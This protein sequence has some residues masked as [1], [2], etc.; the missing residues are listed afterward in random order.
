MSK[1]ARPGIKAEAMAMMES[2]STA[3]EVSVLTGIEIMTLHQMR[4]RFFGPFPRRVRKTYTEETKKIARDLYSSGLTTYEV[5]ERLDLN[6]SLVWKW[7]SLASIS[8]PRSE[9]KNKRRLP[10]ASESFNRILSLEEVL[11]DALLG[12]EGWRDRAEEL[13]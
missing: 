2:G 11:K 13:L 5:G 1:H 12:A 3:K 10:L 6:P 8:R 4:H 9:V 7:I